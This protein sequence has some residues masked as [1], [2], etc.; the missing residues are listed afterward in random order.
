[1][2]TVEAPLNV[3]PTTNEIAPVVRRRV[4][5]LIYLM[6][7]AAC[8]AALATPNPVLSAGSVLVLL[9]LIRLLWRA[10]E[11]PI[12]LFAAGYQWIQIT[13]LVIQANYQGKVLAA[14]AT[15][16]RTEDAIWLSLAG[17]MALAFGMR[18]GVARVSVKS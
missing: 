18:A 3:T 4:P 11:P 6:S 12:L 5:L 14:L 10:G 2:Y 13:T 7:G 16:D 8:V 1:M 17:L 15:Y 9:A